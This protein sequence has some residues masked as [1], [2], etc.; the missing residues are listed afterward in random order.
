MRQTQ[1]VNVVKISAKQDEYPLNKD[2]NSQRFG[3]KPTVFQ[4]LMCHFKN[5]IGNTDFD[6]IEKEYQ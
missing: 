2:F 6:I 5:M 1:K 4:M 3:R